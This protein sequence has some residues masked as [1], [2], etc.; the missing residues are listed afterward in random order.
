MALL[1]LWIPGSCGVPSLHAVTCLRSGLCSSSVHDRDVAFPPLDGFAFDLREVS[2]PQAGAVSF[3]L[4]WS[5]RLSCLLTGHY[6]SFNLGSSSLAWL[7]GETSSVFLLL[8][9]PSGCG[10]PLGSLM[11]FVT[12][13]RQRRFPLKEVFFCVVASHL[14]VVS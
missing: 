12:I 9:L 1:C 3:G 8:C 7:G 14:G 6:C 4:R 10:H 2:L 11:S 5:A 13:D